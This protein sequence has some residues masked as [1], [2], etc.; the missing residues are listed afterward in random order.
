MEID[1]NELINNLIQKIAILEL[2]NSKKDVLINQLQN[3]VNNQE[4]EMN[5]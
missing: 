3:E 5:K 2:E 4:G 1:I